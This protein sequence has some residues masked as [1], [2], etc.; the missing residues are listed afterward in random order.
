MNAFKLNFSFWISCR[1]CP[2]PPCTRKCPHSLCYTKS[3]FYNKGVCLIIIYLLYTRSS[4][5]TG[6]IMESI[7][8]S[9]LF[10]AC[11]TCDVCE[12][13]LL[14]VLYQ[15]LR[16]KQIEQY[17]KFYIHSELS[18]NMYIKCLEGS[19]HSLWPSF[20]GKILSKRCMIWE[21][22]GIYETW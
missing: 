5:K 22:F 10:N 16:G 1:S 20:I 9:K 15:R 4:V 11:K 19:W 12:S 14:I 2:L 13:K 6:A 7:V 17:Y 18:R 3:C 8:Y 21:A